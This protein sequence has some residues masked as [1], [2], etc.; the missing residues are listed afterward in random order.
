MCYLPSFQINKI[1]VS[2]VLYTS[3]IPLKQEDKFA[4][5]YACAGI[6]ETLWQV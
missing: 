2:D 6:P 4:D 1:S 5:N 3:F